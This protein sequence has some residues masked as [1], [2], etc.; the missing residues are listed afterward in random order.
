MAATL[1]VQPGEIH[2]RVQ[3]FDMHLAVAH[4][5]DQHATLGQVIGRFSQHASHQIQAIIAASQ[6]HRRLVLVFGR[7]VGEILGVDIRRVGDDQVETLPR[8]PGETIALHA[9]DALLQAMTLDIE[10]GHLQRVERQIAQHHFRF[11][12]S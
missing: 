6:A 8:Q 3:R 10:V 4:L 1:E 5:D 9:V 2:F 11:G 7:H 12:N